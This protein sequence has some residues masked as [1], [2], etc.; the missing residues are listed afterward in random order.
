[1]TRPRTCPSTGTAP[2]TSTTSPTNVRGVSHVLATVVEDP[3]EPQPQRQRRSRASPAARWA[4]TTRSPSARTTRAAAPS[5]RR[6]A[7]RPRASTPT[8]VKHLRGRDQLGRGPDRPG[9]QRLRR[10]RA[11]RTTS[12]PRS[13]RRRTCDEPIGFDQFPDGRIIQ[14]A[15]Q[16]H[17]APARPGHGHDDRS[18]PT[19]R[20][21]ACRRRCA[22]TPTRRTA[23]TAGAV[24][25]D[26]ATRTTGSTSTTRRRRSRTSSCRRA[27]SSRRRR[28]TRTPP[29]SAASLTAWDPYVGYF[30]LS[31]FKFVDDAQRAGAPGPRLRAA[32]PARLQQPPGVLP[33]RGRHRL[34]QAQQPVDGHG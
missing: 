16:R 33:R 25:N 3:F 29:N 31:R 4:P 22:S 15:R 7:T 9:L 28:R 26:F 20:T 34:R 30:Q 27:R 32:D 6:S 12:R 21:R 14:T 19:S 1:M 18:S 10:D 2:T 23:S 5:T 11:A 24:D 8:L 13:P 17:G